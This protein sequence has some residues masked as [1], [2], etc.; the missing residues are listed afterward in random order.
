M[1]MKNKYFSI[2]PS[3]F[4]KYD[5]SKESELSLSYS[6]RINRPTSENLNP[7]TSYADPYNL[8]LGNPALKPEYINSFDFGYSLN[9]KKFNIT[10]SVFYRQTKSVISRV[11]QFYDNGASSV[12]YANLDNSVSFGPEIV[13]VYRPFPWMKNM[14]SGNGN[15]IKFTDDTPG[16]NWNNSGFF[17]S[18]KYAGTFEFWKKTATLQVNARYNSPVVTAQGIFQ[19]R[20]S[21]DLSG[22]KTLKDGKWTIG[23]RLTDVFDTQEFRFQVIQPGATQQAGFKQ[24]TRRF[25]LN[26]SYKFGKYDIKKAKV[27]GEGGGFDF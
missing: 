18:V 12:S 14:L 9:K 3:A 23:F 13:F 24:N 22:D 19:P 16:S 2:F 27:N 8:R 4:L 10:A 6:R 25:Y 21:A 5:I 1:W 11:K 26:V 7:F 17:W 20:A 15:N